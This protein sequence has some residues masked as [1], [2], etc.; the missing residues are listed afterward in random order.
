LLAAASAPGTPRPDAGFVAALFEVIRE[1][2]AL[3][4]RLRREDDPGTLP[5]GT[6]G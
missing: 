2:D 6:R 3:V 1:D 4:A 5:G